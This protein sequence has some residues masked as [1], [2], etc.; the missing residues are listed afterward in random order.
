MTCHNGVARPAGEDQSFSRKECRLAYSEVLRCGFPLICHRCEKAFR[1]VCGFFGHQK[2]CGTNSRAVKA[3]A[4]KAAAAAALRKANRTASSTINDNAINTRNV[5]LLYFDR[6]M[7][8]RQ[9]LLDYDHLVS[10]CAISW[11]LLEQLEQSIDLLSDWQYLESSRQLLPFTPVCATSP[12]YSLSCV[13]VDPSSRGTP[14]VMSATGGVPGADT[15]CERLF[16]ME[17]SR[18]VASATDGSASL[19]MFCG[20]P[21]TALDWSET[22]GGSAGLHLAVSCRRHPSPEQPLTPVTCTHQPATVQLWN[23]QAQMSTAP[24]LLYRLCLDVE[25]GPL[26]QLRWAPGVGSDQWLGALAAACGDG[27]VRIYLLPTRAN[28]RQVLDK[29][30]SKARHYTAPAAV[31]L[32]LFGGA[33]SPCLRV[34]WSRA[35]D[36]CVVTAG[37]GDGTLAVW[38]VSTCNPLLQDSGDGGR[39]VYPIQ[40]LDAHCG[41]V[42]ALCTAPRGDSFVFSGGR[43]RQLHVWDLEE[44]CRLPRVITKNRPPATDASWPGPGPG[45]RKLTVSFDHSLHA[46]TASTTIMDTVVPQ[47]DM[48]LFTLLANCCSVATHAARGLAAAGGESGVLAVAQWRHLLVTK[49]KAGW[50]QCLMRANVVD[51]REASDDSDTPCDDVARYTSM[52]QYGVV[53]FCDVD[54]RYASSEALHLEQQLHLD[55]SWI[56]N[57]PFVSLNALSW[58]ENSRRAS[59][60]L[61]VGMEC[62]FVRILR[63]P[64]EL[65][66]SHR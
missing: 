33:V 45:T 28:L 17:G 52:C 43:D 65:Y 50:R 10:E 9:Q 59:D 48:G 62:G 23:V 44:P 54:R 46:G 34:Q 22:R 27:C 19:L 63:A 21:V 15:P 38:H 7:P 31:Q 8:T 60:L 58:S 29:K 24:T 18:H 47:N 40:V 64:G 3:A 55:G 11:H 41:H 51:T 14:V 16:V 53:H 37:F 36:R 2:V 20:G 4:T 6:L 32:C 5:N 61:A 26:W 13:S 39:I 56:V 12:R 42:S 1:S 57:Y 30:S 25:C 35:S 49:H 66:S